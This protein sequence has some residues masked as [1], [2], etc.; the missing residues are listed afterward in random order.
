MCLF[1]C[2]YFLSKSELK[3]G[4]I[5]DTTVDNI[6]EVDDIDSEAGDDIQNMMIDYEDPSNEVKL[7]TK[8]FRIS[9]PDEEFQ[10]FVYARWLP[11]KGGR[12]KFAVLTLEQHQK[13]KRVVNKT[14]G[15]KEKKS[16]YFNTPLW[17]GKTL[18]QGILNV[19]DLNE[20]FIKN[21]H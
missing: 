9:D 7:I 2:F 14:T 17:V 4:S 3:D 10:N 5:V 16:F 6:E 15:L 18:A 21:R 1:F 19:T 13:G 20:E 12:K 8:K 11:C